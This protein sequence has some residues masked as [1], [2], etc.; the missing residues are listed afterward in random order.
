MAPKKTCASSK[1]AARGTN[2]DKELVPSISS[3][4]TLNSLVVHGALTD[5]ATGGWRPAAGE[6]FPTPHTNQLVV[7]E[8]Y[9]F[10]GF[11]IPVHPF[12]CGLID[13]YGINLCNLSLNSIL[14]VSMFINLCESYLG[15]LPHFNLFC[16]FFYLKINGGVAPGW[17]VVP[18]YTC[19]MG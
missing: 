19:G 2:R 5:R 10:H 14:H 7:F 1:K 13:Y 8:D 4:A 3:E 15:I 9:F 11:G 17:S 18:I 6:P 16:H 12:L